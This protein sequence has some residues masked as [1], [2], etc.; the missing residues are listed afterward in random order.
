MG[1]PLWVFLRIYQWLNAKRD[2]TPFVMYWKFVFFA[3]NHRYG[4]KLYYSISRISIVSALGHVQAMDCLL[5]VQNQGP[6][7]CLLLQVNHRP[8]YWSNLPCDWPSTAWAY[9]KQETENGTCLSSTFYITTLIKLNEYR[10]HL[11]DI[12]RTDVGSQTYIKI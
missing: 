12:Q 10:L 9:F 1:C 8:G 7:F 3:W 6:I 2:V 11:S 5:W 4:T